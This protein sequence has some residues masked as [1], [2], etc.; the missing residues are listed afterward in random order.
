RPYPA[1]AGGTVPLSGCGSPDADADPL[2]SIWDLDGD[3]T[4]G[5]T[6][7]LAARGDETGPSP[8][9]NAAGLAAGPYTVRLRVFDPRGAFS[10]VATTVNVAT[11]AAPRVS[12]TVVDGG[13]AQRSRVT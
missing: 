8:V 9:F 4:F 6:G 7:A 1:S 5:E 11:P 3:G 13:A 2:T 12:S 10:E